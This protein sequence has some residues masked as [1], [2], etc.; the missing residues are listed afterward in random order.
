MNS[1]KKLKS[2]KITMQM[3]ES[4]FFAYRKKQNN[5]KDPNKISTVISEEITKAYLKEFFSN[6]RE[7]EL[8]KKHKHTF[9]TTNLNLDYSFFGINLKT[10]GID[11]TRVKQGRINLG[12]YISDI[13]V[14][15]G[16]YTWEDYRKL[17]SKAID[18][19]GIRESIT[20]LVKDY[21]KLTYSMETVS[22][23]YIV[24]PQPNPWR[25][26][27]YFCADCNTTLQLKT[28][29]PEI[30]ELYL[31][32]VPF[33]VNKEDSIKELRNKLGFN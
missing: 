1:T 30:Y 12:I 22:D 27:E 2:E 7:I 16:H 31:K 13:L 29:Y 10:L 14:D 23:K 9:S 11:E 20:N 6:N 32:T 17:I 19:Q 24:C 5:Q 21:Y 33:L 8:Y 25:E 28:K 26:C 4:L 15:K 3:R 18:N